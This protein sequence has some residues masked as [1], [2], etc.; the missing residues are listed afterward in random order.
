MF[1]GR[2]RPLPILPRHRIFAIDSSSCRARTV[3]F[4]GILHY[5]AVKIARDLSVSERGRSSQGL[6]FHRSS[7]RGRNTPVAVLLLTVDVLV[8]AQEVL[9]DSGRCPVP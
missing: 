9:A 1:D 7:K 8:H 3:A 6:A 4:T 2:S 5:S